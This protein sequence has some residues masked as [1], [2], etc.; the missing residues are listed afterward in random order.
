[1]VS[2]LLTIILGAYFLSADVLVAASGKL[3]DADPLLMTACVLMM[4]AHTFVRALRI[5]VVVD[6]ENQ[7][8]LLT[9][10]CA[11]QS[12]IGM[13]AP[14]GLSHIAFIFLLKK[15]HAVNLA[16]IFTGMIAIRI[17][18]VFLLG[19][20]TLAIVPYYHG[21]LSGSKI[22]GGTLTGLI[23]GTVTVAGMALYLVIRGARRSDHEHTAA[24]AGWLLGN[25][26][27][28]RHELA[29]T[30]GKILLWRTLFLTG[31]I[32]ITQFGVYGLM[33]LAMGFEISLS[34]GILAF[35]VLTV[36]NIMPVH[37]IAGIGTHH[38][39]WFVALSTAG[40]AD[41]TA[42]LAAATSHFLLIIVYLVIAV[43]GILLVLHGTRSV[44][45][46]T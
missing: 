18:D 37:G 4:M 21:V 27:R 33:Y 16:R 40:V 39:A 5:G 20:L 1:M 29:R 24:R 35:L 7:P 31:S 34:G 25:L 46:G 22:S 38:L 6:R 43:P 41:E 15:L 30:G 17:V 19:M 14:S 26:D 10:T 28:L 32:W 2:I 45:H 9:G 3:L 42:R 44:P 13:L 36:I 8:A 12:T 11:V 23:V